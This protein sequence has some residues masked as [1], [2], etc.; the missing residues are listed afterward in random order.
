MKVKKIFTMIISVA[1]I[2]TATLFIYPLV[3]QESYYNSLVQSPSDKGAYLNY[4][5]TRCMG[6]DGISTFDVFSGGDINIT[7]TGNSH[8][9][10]KINCCFRG[11]QVI[12]R[13]SET[14]HLTYSSSFIDDFLMNKSLGSDFISFGSVPMEKGSYNN[15]KATD[16]HVWVNGGSSVIYPL[17][18]QG[19]GYR[20]GTYFPG[21][22]FTYCLEP[23][24]YTP[25]KLEHSP[26]QSANKNTSL[27]K[28]CYNYFPNNIF[29][30]S[31]GGYT[32]PYSVF[33]SGAT[34]LLPYLYKY[35]DTEGN[36]FKL[37]LKSSNLFLAPHSMIYD[38]TISFI[39]LTWLWALLLMALIGGEVK[40]KRNKARKRNR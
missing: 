39:I 7:S 3:G 21:F 36:L 20:A 14:L 11:N 12:N 2:L 13:W 29:L 25:T 33:L 26:I 10:V 34:N 1:L 31:S 24:R 22:S 28:Q 30:V 8:F 23:V 6:Y 17:C 15:I 40:V 32:I 9:Q 18:G 19:L 16:D 38:Q 5:Y 37:N 4:S 27:Y 35:N